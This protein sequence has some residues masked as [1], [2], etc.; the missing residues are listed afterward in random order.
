WWVRAL[1][2]IAFHLAFFYMFAALFIGLPYPQAQ[3]A[4]LATAIVSLEVH[5]RMN[6]NAAIG[7]GMANL[8]VAAT[9]SRGYGF[10]FFLLAFVGL[11]L[12][13]LWFADAHDGERRARQ[14]ITP[15]TPADESSTAAPARWGRLRG[16]TPAGWAVRFAVGLLFTGA[17]VFFL[18]PQ[19]AARPLFM[20]ITLSLPIEQ[21]PSASVINPAV[22]L[23]QIQGRVN[24]DNSEYYFGFADQIDLSY[25]GGLSDTVMMLVKSQAWSY[26]RGYALDHYDGRNWNNTDDSLTTIETR[27]RDG[28]FVVDPEAPGYNGEWFVQSFYIMQ[29]MPN[30]IWGGGEPFRAFVASNSIAVDATGGMRVGS[31]LSRGMTYSVIS[32]RVDFPAEELRA[33]DTTTASEAIRARYLQLPDTVTERTR[34][35]AL[36]WTAGDTTDY[37]RVISIRDQLLLYEYDFFPPPQPLNSDAVD[38]FLFE[39]QR[40]VCEHYVSAMVI[41]LRTLDIPARFVVG[42]GAGEFNPLSGYY[43]VRANDAHAWVEVYF[44]EKGWIPFDPTPGWTESP[45]SG[46]VE[47]W[48]FSGYLQDNILPNIPF[49]AV[50]AAGAS[51]FAFLGSLVVPAVIIAAVSGVV[52]AGLWMW[53]RATHGRPLRIPPDAGRRAVFRAYWWA[54]VFT[55]RRR[56]GQTVRE[57]LENKA[58]LRGLRDAVEMAAYRPSPLDEA[59]VDRARRWWRRGEQ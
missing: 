21:E 9:L 19:F 37:D 29:P 40:G 22:P 46:P 33:V 3:F 16:R 42:Y 5:S 35:L 49:D 48:A 53:R 54:Q 11:W 58:R 43:T 6:L 4:M 57:H 27:R 15:T 26:W 20:P 8:Y 59:T 47:T 44:P 1:A 24:R 55:G 14:T 34:A 45:Y 56:T 10:L 7:L 36:E 30:I 23:V 12:A 13:Y 28:S 2:F 39:D 52:Y 18:T 17:V 38:L 41:M 32:N 51:M 50:A 25:R 31:P